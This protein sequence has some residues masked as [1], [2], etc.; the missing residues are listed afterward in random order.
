MGMYDIN[1]LKSQGVPS[2]A[3]SDWMGIYLKTDEPTDIKDFYW[4]IRSFI[5]AYGIDVFWAFK[6]RQMQQKYGY[7]YDDAAKSTY[8]RNII[9]DEERFIDE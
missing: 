3:F 7:T 6:D 9:A 4:K 5:D 8:I 2:A 1:R